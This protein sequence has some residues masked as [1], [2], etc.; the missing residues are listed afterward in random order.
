MHNGGCLLHSFFSFF[1][2]SFSRA[3]L[4]IHILFFFIYEARFIMVFLLVYEAGIHIDIFI[5]RLWM[6]II[7]LQVSATTLIVL[8]IKYILSADGLWWKI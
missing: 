5:L 2:I 1:R 6:D 3:T 7:V 8:I 4:H